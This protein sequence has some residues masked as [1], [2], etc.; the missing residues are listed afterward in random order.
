M[1]RVFLGSD[2]STPAAV[3]VLGSSAPTAGSS[4]SPALPSHRRTPSEADRWLEEVT[5]SVRGPQ[6]QQQQTHP[7]A[8]AFPPGP[9]APGVAPPAGFMPMLPPRQ[10]AYHPHAQA[11]G[12]YPV[13]NGLA[14]VAPPPPPPTPPLPFSPAP[15]HHPQML[16]PPAVVSVPLQYD[17]THSHALAATHYNK[18]LLL[19]PTL[20]P[21]PLLQPSSNGSVAF[22]GGVIGENWA[23]AASHQLVAPPSPAAAAPPPHTSLPPTV[24]PLT[25]QVDAFEAQWVALEGR[26]HPHTS[27]SP[28]NPFSSEL[29]K[30]FE[31]QL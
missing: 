11:P 8:V 29:H 18:P 15:H 12:P 3:A 13:S 1:V 22:N 31:I 19:P 25:G 7:P 30:T 23:A 24:P 6:Q 28:T 4:S 21:A 2:W 17:H 16:P 27:P 26:S 9:V 5:K 10:P 14:F 20:S